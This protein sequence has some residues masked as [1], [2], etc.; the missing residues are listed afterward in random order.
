MTSIF[1]SQTPA[2][3]NQSD[4][5]TYSLGTTFYSTSAGN[6]T[7]VRW[8]FPTTLPT[9]TI[10]GKLWSNS[11][12]ELGSA[13]FSSPTAG[14][15]NT[16]TFSSSVAISANTPY[17]VSVGPVNRYVATSGLFSS[18]GITNSPL[19]APQDN[20]NPLG[21]GTLRN[22]KFDIN[23]SHIFPTSTFGGNC[24]FPDLVFAG[25]GLSGSAGTATETDT[26]QSLGRRKTRA[27]GISSETNT[28]VAVGR[29]KSRTVGIAASTEAA[30]ALGRLKTRTIGI[31]VDTGAALALGR[32]KTR[33][34]G[35][36]TETDVALAAGR[37]KTRT[38]GTV[39][40]TDTAVGFSWAKRRAPLLATETGTAVAVVGS[41]RRA[42]SYAVEIDTALGIG[43][44]PVPAAL[45]PARVRLSSGRRRLTTA[46]GHRRVVVASR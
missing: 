32:L 39:T 8:Y 4:G 38:V 5:N 27:V 24:Y 20:T 18:A 35:A 34:V 11:G 16:A 9:G 46:S 33:A 25:L 26:A 22:G 10:T 17:V 41:K 13:T 36:A 12:T 43:G 6:A 3:T 44:A 40:E 31:A 42:V 37:I 2:L 45:I 7:G 30:L 21:G 14:A 29:R 23:A 1:T 19:V 28:A 15:W